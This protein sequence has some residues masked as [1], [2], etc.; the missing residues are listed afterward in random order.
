MQSTTNLI[1][2]TEIAKKIIFENSNPELLGKG[3]T[4]VGEFFLKKQIINLKDLTQEEK[5]IVANNSF[6]QASYT[7]KSP[8][9]VV[10]VK[11]SSTL[12]LVKNFSDLPKI[13]LNEEQQ[14]KVN[15]FLEKNKDNPNFYNG[16]HIAVEEMLYDATKN[17]L[18][19]KAK[20]TKYG[21]MSAVPEVLKGS[22]FRLGVISPIIT[23]DNKTYLLER[24]DLLK[25]R[26]SV[27]GF[28][29]PIEGS[30]DNL[31]NRT[32]YNEFIEEVAGNPDGTARD[33]NLVSKI[34]LNSISFRGMHSSPEKQPAVIPT[35]EFIAPIHL[36]MDSKE[37]ES[38]YLQ[39]NFSKDRREHTIDY[40]KTHILDGVEYVTNNY[41]KVDLSNLNSILETLY[42]GKAGN[43]LYWP[44]VTSA[45]SSVGINITAPD[46]FKQITKILPEELAEELL[47]NNSYWSE[48][49]YIPIYSLTPETPHL[50]AIVRW[51]LEAEHWKARDLTDEIVQAAIDKN[52]EH[53]EV[54]D[55]RWRWHK[56]NL[57]I[58]DNQHSSQI[59]T[60]E[61][62]NL[63]AIVRRI[64][65]KETTSR[66]REVLTPKIVEAALAK[67]DENYEVIKKMWNNFTQTVDKSNENLYKSTWIEYSEQNSSKEL[68]NT[69][70]L[71]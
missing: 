22:S 34:L 35:G 58:T 10:F 40:T 55:Q 33:P 27:S 5:A 53:S 47:F 29:Q 66:Q 54:I 6:V 46:K 41:H 9:T 12:E 21:T 64:L 30:L 23:K 2:L 31:I 61:T 63:S 25:L 60:P 65:E 49:K 42:S 69:Q 70:K 16:D 28:L 39:Y 13:E 44:I 45:L 17:I 18:Y 59:L 11:D 3:M 50:S 4:G 8:P 1:N 67:N 38:L 32:A 43:F 48:E 57:T 71:V 36:N 37:F 14:K 56:L 20:S 26:S 15:D 62:Q 19:I 68:D 24:N 52:D 7:F 51:I